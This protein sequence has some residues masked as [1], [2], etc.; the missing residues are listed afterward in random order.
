MNGAK[1]LDATIVI[2]GKGTVVNANTATAALVTIEEEHEE[3]ICR[4]FSVASDDNSSFAFS[5]ASDDAS[6]GESETMSA[7]V[8]VAV[9]NKVVKVDNHSPAIAPFFLERRSNKNTPASASASASASA[10]PPSSGLS[11]TA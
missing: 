4:K 5:A 7:A 2:E 11:A 6:L 3:N 9:K 1:R 10:H 8:T